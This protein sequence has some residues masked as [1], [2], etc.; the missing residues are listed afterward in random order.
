MDLL[1]DRQLYFGGGVALLAVLVALLTPLRD[2]L[3]EVP[4]PWY[5]RWTD[6]PIKYLGL[7][8]RKPIYIQ[9][10]H[11]KYGPI[12]RVSPRE[13]YVADPAAAQQI[14]RIKK[15][16][17]K[18]PWYA[19]FVSGQDSVFSARDVD[20][21]RRH[22]KLLSAPLS[23]PGLKA[24]LPQVEAKVRLAIQRMGEEAETRGAADILKWWMFMATDVIGELSFGESFRM[25]EHGKMNQYGADLQ[26]IGSFAAL[27]TTFPFLFRLARVYNVPVPFMNKAKAASLRILSYA[28][29]S[30]QRHRTIVENEGSNARPTLLSKLYKAGDDETMTQNEMCGNAQSFIVAGS[31]T[32]SNTLTYLVWAVCR[33]P[34]VKAKLIKELEQ[35]PDDFVYDDVKGLPYLDQVIDETLR[36]Y[37]AAPSG[38]PRAVPPEGVELAGYHLPG[39]YTVSTQAYSLHLND[40]AFPEPHVFNPERWEKPTRLMKDS[41]MPF[42][43]DSRNCLGLHL[44]LMELRLATTRFFRAFPNAT[45]SGLDGMSDAD[46]E[47]ELYFLIIP[48]GHRCLIQLF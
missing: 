16:F 17:L 23:E 6:L 27:R 39:G 24:F 8:G 41:F 36:L 7:T 38:L 2:P 42:G 26:A 3:S 29:E 44:A 13:V 5:A 19:N 32:T 1:S 45:V 4:G 20:V 15:K 37:P 22:R 33:H 10:L 21:H 48:K 47:A 18:D 34:A 40:D 46:M 12:V 28:A 31:D 11:L 9:T 14:H 30:I 35:L 43:G 25:L